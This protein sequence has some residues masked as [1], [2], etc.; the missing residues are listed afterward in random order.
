[1]SR[2]LLDYKGIIT[3]SQAY[4]EGS[5]PFTRSKSHRYW[6]SRDL[7]LASFES[8]RLAFDPA[9][10]AATEGMFAFAV[11]RPTA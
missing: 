8:W 11:R 5:I 7:N 4:D 3:D 10:L 9:Y 6:R 2:K 1:M